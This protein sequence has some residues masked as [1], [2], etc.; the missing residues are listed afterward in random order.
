MKT[1]KMLGDISCIFLACIG[2][3]ITC[4]FAYYL[5][6]N[7]DIT[8][9][10]NNIGDQV[11]VDIIQK[12]QSENDLTQNEIAMLEDR[13]FMQVNYYDNSKS[14]GVELC[15][16]NFN[17]FTNWD[18]LSVNYRSSGMQYV[19]NYNKNGTINSDTNGSDIGWIWNAFSDEVRTNSEAQYYVSPDFYYYDTTNGITWNGHTANEGSLATNLNRATQF[20]V[21]I[22]NRPFL[23]QLTGSYEKKIGEK[24]ILFG[25]IKTA[26]VYSTVYYTY[27]NVFKNAIKAVKSNSVGCGD[28][29]ITVDLSDYFTIREY[30]TE[31]GKFKTDNVT[32]VIK[33]Y[34]VLKFHYEANGAIS[35][36][37]S[38]FGLIENNRKFALGEGEEYDTTYWQERFVY[39][40]T[41][42]D[43]HLRYSSVY[44]GY[45]ASLSLATQNMF[46][47]MPRA[48]VNIVLNL[49]GTNIIG[50]DYN[51][52][53]NF[54]IDTVKIIGSPQTFYLLEKCLYNSNIKTFIRSSGITLDFG[55]NAINYL[56]SEV[57]L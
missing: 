7:K 21:K 42:K 53:E 47:Q 43:L 20:I 44:D 24:K 48:K 52:F 29:Y 45:F 55:T 41:E 33:N 40:L 19:G 4:F 17:Y 57:I 49:T 31:T 8:V 6:F 50:F 39:N 32:N 25:L 23:I 35:S 46:K 15:E 3:V 1:L 30:D 38:M 54:A 13:W 34:A 18:L 28:Y 26:D 12:V 2:V 16:L 9:G 14:N 36:S 51:A 5:I 10:V 56:Y 11:G 22:D 37:Q 27:A